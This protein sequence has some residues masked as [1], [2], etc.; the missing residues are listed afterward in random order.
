MTEII[1]ITKDTWRFEEDGV[2]F[3]LLI[4]RTVALLVDSGMNTQNAKELAESVTD[5]PLEL[6]N[7]HADRD[8]I[9]CNNEFE[10][11]YMNPAEG[12][13]YFRDG[14]KGE[15]R[16]VWDGDVL[17]LGDR[18][19]EIICMPGH[20]PGSIAIL[21]PAERFLIGGDGIQD[22][23]IFMFGPYRDMN[24]YI[25]SMKRLDVIR[26][27]FDCIYPSHGTFPVGADIIPELIRD[28]EDILAGNMI[29][30]QG[31]MHGNK[32]SIY[33]TK[34]ATFLCDPEL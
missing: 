19:L 10:Y 6:I 11:A 33:K 26:D 2:R 3:F 8:H 17:D 13:N 30:A 27:R 24:S 34:T 23:N 32:I 5:L 14:R 15:I 31:E 20:T 29:P 21:D 22:G 1:Q 18:K 7:T 9:A 12:V 16:P 28:A 25:I 4:G